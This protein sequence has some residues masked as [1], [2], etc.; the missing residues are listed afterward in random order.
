MVPPCRLLLP[1]PFSH[2]YYASIIVD[3][4][5]LDFKY[6]VV[7]AEAVE[8]LYDLVPR[9]EG[10]REMKLKFLRDNIS[11]QMVIMILPTWCPF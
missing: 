2:L 10:K 11:E 6:P 8:Q 1:A 4:C 5:K 9:V 7:L 3:L